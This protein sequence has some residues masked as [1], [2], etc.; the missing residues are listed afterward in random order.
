MQ[1]VW[2]SLRQQGQRQRQ[3][4]L[5]Q[6]VPG[7]QVRKGWVLRVLRRGRVRSKKRQV[8]RP[9]ERVQPW[10][11]YQAEPNVVSS[12]SPFFPNMNSY[13]HPVNVHLR[14][15]CLRHSSSLTLVTIITKKSFSVML[16]CDTGFSSA[17]IFPIC[18]PKNKY[19]RNVV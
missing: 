1:R 7:Q 17:R 12:Q 16:Y 19:T 15:C 2:G 11:M 3:R 18:S 6:R 4:V 13:Y 5:P 8:Q 10:A 9:W 14:K